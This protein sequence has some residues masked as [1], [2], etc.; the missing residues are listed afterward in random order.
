MS[1]TRFPKK[2]KPAYFTPALPARARST[3]TGPSFA[4]RPVEH[5][6]SVCD[7]RGAVGIVELIEHRYRVTDP[8]GRVIGSFCTLRD[9]TR[10]FDGNGR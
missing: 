1:N 6:I 4:R 8:A 3:I 10:A 2:R 9:A 7:G 5:R